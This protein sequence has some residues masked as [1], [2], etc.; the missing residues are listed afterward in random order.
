MIDA[1]DTKDRGYVIVDDILATLD[2]VGVDHRVNREE[3]ALL[4]YDAY[5]LVNTES[6]TDTSSHFGNKKHMCLV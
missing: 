3:L 1:M 6:P 2:S 5:S 4:F